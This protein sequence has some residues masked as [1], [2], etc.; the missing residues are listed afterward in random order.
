MTTK[1]SDANS[2]E[3]LIK[4]LRQQVMDMN[5]HYEDSRTTAKDI[6]AQINDLANAVK[7][8]GISAN[9]IRQSVESS[10]E[11]F[12]SQKGK[13]NDKVN[14]ASYLVDQALENSDKTVLN[15]EKQTRG[16][17]YLRQQMEA[18]QKDTQVFE[19][20]LQ[21]RYQRVL[22]QGE[23]LKAIPS[24]SIFPKPDFQGTKAKVTE[25]LGGRFD[26]EGLMSDMD[27][28]RTEK[29]RL[30]LQFRQS[31]VVYPKYTPPKVSAPESR[32]PIVRKQRTIPQY[33]SDGRRSSGRSGGSKGK[34]QAQFPLDNKKKTIS[35]KPKNLINLPSTAIECP[36]EE[37]TKPAIKSSDPPKKPT[38]T[39][40]DLLANPIP[41]SRPVPVAASPSPAPISQRQPG[42]EIFDTT[43]EASRPIEGPS[44]PSSKET[45][46]GPSQIEVSKPEEKKTIKPDNLLTPQFKIPSSSVQTQEPP[47]PNLDAKAVDILTDFVLANQLGTLKAPPIP[48]EL[49]SSPSKWLGMG[50]LNDLIREG[51]NVDSDLIE[52]LGREVLAEGIRGI[53]GDLDFD[54]AHGKSDKAPIQEEIEEED[55]Y[56]DEDFDEYSSEAPSEKPD[57]LS[58]KV[59][60]PAKPVQPSTF[61]TKKSEFVPGTAIPA[62]TPAQ[63]ISVEPAQLPGAI[64]QAGT[65][66]GIEPQAMHQ[67]PGDMNALLSPR[68]LGQMSA[69]AIHT[70]VSSLIASGH[71]ASGAAPPAPQTPI[72]AM[73]QPQAPS[74]TTMP[75]NEPVVTS[76]RSVESERSARQQGRL[77]QS[78]QSI[79]QS[80]TREESKSARSLPPELADFFATPAGRDLYAMIQ[81][82]HGQVDPQKIMEKFAQKVVKSPRNSIPFLNVGYKPETEVREGPSRTPED[83]VFGRVPTQPKPRFDLSFE[84][85]KI[86]S[87]NNQVRHEINIIPHKISH[88]DIP[89]SVSALSESDSDLRSQLSIGSEI[90][91]TEHPDFLGGFVDYVRKAQGMEEGQIIPSGGLSDG[92]IRFSQSSVSSG[93]VSNVSGDQPLDIRPKL[94]ISTADLMSEDDCA[95]SVGEFDPYSIFKV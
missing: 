25:T 44:V 24:D 78:E 10:L 36:P 9:E 32:G 58:D 8:G 34:G 77:D 13:I 68:I 95:S 54:K 85:A 40:D 47:V 33:N 94:N 87:E 63:N 26:Y 6:M 28:I 73:P 3:E 89:S 12:G 49:R 39:V 14:E 4:P 74:A 66:Q 91:S 56:G 41:V 52:K 71:M 15:F 38:V 70:Y 79:H 75:S 46:R 43:R 35:T 29:N 19:N 37:K 48:V 42:S 65:M 64:P 82:E 59:P 61:E 11:K 31:A 92:E 45:P 18:V 23:K 50:D 69:A 20:E 17:E 16:I 7:T 1:K 80:Q 90:F 93:E 30:I 67:Q 22:E 83:H 86:A 81:Q 62:A 72:V 76:G 51:I 27:G 84:A 5:K 21:H 53:K 55:E 2:L 60:E 88:I 57:V